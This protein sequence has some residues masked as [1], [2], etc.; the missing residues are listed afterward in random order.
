MPLLHHKARGKPD[1]KVNKLWAHGMN[2]QHQRTG[3]L[4][5]DACSSSYS[6]WN[7]DKNS[8][9]QECKSDELMEVGTGRPIYEQ[10]P[11]LF[12]EH[13]DRFVVD[14]DDMDSDSRRIRHVVIAQG[15]WSSAKDSRPILTRCNTRQ[16]QTFFNLVNVFVFDIGSICNHGK[17]SLRNF[18]F[19]QKIQEKISQWNRCPTYL[20][21]S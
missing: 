18:T 16:Q 5:E 2:E 8:S 15:E 1:M 14:D 13:T 4:V 6:E 3:R 21:S 7:A 11:G 20:K 12:T 9:S 17:E 10:P 19:H